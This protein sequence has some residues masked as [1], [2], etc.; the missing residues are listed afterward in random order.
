MNK[1]HLWWENNKEIEKK[2]TGEEALKNITLYWYF[3]YIEVTYSFYY[4]T[5]IMVCLFYQCDWKNS[6][7]LLSVFSD[8]VMYFW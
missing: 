2:Q 4:C 1:T 6:A 7:G 3:L 5:Y 8:V